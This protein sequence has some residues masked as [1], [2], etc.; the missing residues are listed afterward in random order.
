MLNNGPFIRCEHY[1]CGCTDV[2]QGLVTFPR[3]RQ[4]NNV[5]L[6]QVYDIVS[7]SLHPFCLGLLNY[8]VLRC[9]R[10]VG[11]KLPMINTV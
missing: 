5:W 11:F 6:G 4:G 10:I 1:L 9:E 3:N 7:Q 8:A 2:L